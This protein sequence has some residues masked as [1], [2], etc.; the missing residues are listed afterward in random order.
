MTPGLPF[1]AL[2]QRKAMSLNYAGK[3]AI[4]LHKGWPT[5]AV[6]DPF[7]RVFHWAARRR[8]L[9]VALVTSLL[10]AA[11]LDQRACHRRNQRPRHWWRRGSCGASWDL[12]TARFAELRP[13]AGDPARRTS[14]PAA[15]SGT[16]Q[17][18]IGHNPLGAAMIVALLAAVLA[19]PL[20]GIIALGGVLKSGPLAFASSFAIGKAARQVH[21]LLA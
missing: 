13:W 15:A 7:V 12:P 1:D 11:D 3:A 6:W 5:M 9:A 2:F 16:G 20:S 18:H 10:V 21:A 14:Q 17:R 8:G 4:R 19:S